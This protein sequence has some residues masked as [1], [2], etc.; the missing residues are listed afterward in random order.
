MSR[1]TVAVPPSEYLPASQLVHP[2]VIFVAPCLDVIFPAG[3][4][5]AMQTVAYSPAEYVPALQA[6]QPSVLCFAPS[7]TRVA[8]CPEGHTILEQ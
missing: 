6:E 4:L 1:H 7:V 2:S 8:I 3:Q 5:L